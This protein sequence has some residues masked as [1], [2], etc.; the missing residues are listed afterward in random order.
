MEQVVEMFSKRFVITG[1]GD[2]ILFTFRVLRGEYGTS[3]KVRTLNP[4]SDFNMQV[5]KLVSKFV[6]SDPLSMP[7]WITSD[8]GMQAKISEAIENAVTQ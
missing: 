4:E 5:S 8:K 7:K 3:Y 2:T 6:Y 1:I